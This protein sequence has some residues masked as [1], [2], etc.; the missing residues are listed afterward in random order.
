MSSVENMDLTAANAISEVSSEPCSSVGVRLCIWCN[1]DAAREKPQILLSD[2][3]ET[4]ITNCTDA[5][6]LDLVNVALTKGVGEVAIHRHCRLKLSRQATKVRKQ[7]IAEAPASGPRTRAVAGTFQYSTLCLFCTE[8]V[9]TVDTKDGR[10]V[11]TLSFDNK[12]REIIERRKYDGWA[13]KVQARPACSGR[14]YG[15]L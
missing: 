14:L 4:F 6:R 9:T 15:G 1:D 2:G 12:L 13:L 11:S 5:G 3:F 10:K 8:P 7:G